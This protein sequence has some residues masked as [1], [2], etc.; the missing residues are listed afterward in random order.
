VPVSVSITC[1]FYH[2]CSVVQFEFRDGDSFQSTFIIQ[3][4]FNCPWFCFC[5]CF[6][7]FYYMKLRIALSRSYNLGGEGVLMGIAL[8]LL[9]AFANT[10]IFTML[11]L[12]IHEHGG[13]FH[14][15]IASSILFFK[16]L[17]F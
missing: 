14:L 7:L 12:P 15:W 2:Y 6:I 3:D 17:K 8:N 11:I 16:D 13:S 1:G 5:F 9:I 10:V 4:R